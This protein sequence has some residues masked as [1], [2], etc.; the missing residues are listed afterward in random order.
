MQ[1]YAF[2]DN[3]KSNSVIVSIG[4]KS[5]NV[6]FTN[7]G[8]VVSNHTSY[9]A[10]KMITDF[11]SKSYN[12]SYQEAEA[13]KHENAFFL[14]KEQHDLVDDEQKHFADLMRKIIAPLLQK[15]VGWELGYRVKYGVSIDTVYLTGG[16][17]QIT[18]IDGILSE[19]LGKS[20]EYLPFPQEVV[21]I[22]G[23]VSNGFSAFF[24]RYI[25]VFITNN[26]SI[27]HQISCKDNIPAEQEVTSH[28]TL[29][30]LYLLVLLVYVFY[31]LFF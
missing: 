10:G 5:T 24:Y 20:V 27:H 11:I 3:M 19:A 12:V 2:R 23:S 22:D 26:Q 13:Y 21:D 30:P 14:T 28:Y 16:S 7:D 8:M 9:I 29:Y 18:N 6:Y 17:S 31:Y 4:H 1:S 15:L 25:N